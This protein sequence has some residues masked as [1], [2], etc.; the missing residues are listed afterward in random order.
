MC[1]ISSSLARSK[2][3]TR[4]AGDLE[5]RSTNTELCLGH[6]PTLWVCLMF[7]SPCTSPETSKSVIFSA[8]PHG[9]L[10]LAPPSTFPPW[11]PR[12]NSPARTRKSCLRRR[13]PGIGE[14]SQGSKFRRIS[15]VAWLVGV[16]ISSNGRSTWMHESNRSTGKNPGFRRASLLVLA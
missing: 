12:S 5:P 11:T 15:E 9:S 1:G 13:S 8:S 3:P 4:S 2:Y 14:G 10:S 7:L 6:A 16:Q